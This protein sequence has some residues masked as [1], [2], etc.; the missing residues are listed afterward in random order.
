VFEAAEPEVFGWD[1]NNYGPDVNLFV[2][3]SQIVQ[4]ECLRAGIWGT[5]DLWGRVLTYRPPTA[6]GTHG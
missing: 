4:L 1:V 5:P 3:H 2:D 6:S